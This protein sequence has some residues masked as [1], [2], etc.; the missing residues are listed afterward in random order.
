MKDKIKLLTEKLERISGKKVILENQTIEFNSEETILLSTLLQEITD[1]SLQNILRRVLL[2]GEDLKK[3]IQDERP[4]E[5]RR[6]KQKSNYEPLQH[7]LDYTH[8]VVE[9]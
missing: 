8:N 3:V 6:E 7:D 1:M 2:G 9:Y 4:E 5:K